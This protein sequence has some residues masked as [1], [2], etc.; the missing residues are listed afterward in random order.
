VGTFVAV[1]IYYPAKLLRKSP[2]GTKVKVTGPGIRSTGF[3]NLVILLPVGIVIY[4]FYVDRSLNCAPLWD[5]C[6]L[7]NYR[8][9]LRQCHELKISSVLY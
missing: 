5:G 4:H 3:P 7:Q 2:S 1:L 6:K 9:T 8:L